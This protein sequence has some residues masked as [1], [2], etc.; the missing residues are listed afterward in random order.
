MSDPMP[1][2]LVLIPGICGSKLRK[3]GKEL[4]ALSGHA[5]LHL[6]LTRG[7][8]LNDLI[9]KA[10]PPD[11]D[12]LGDGVVADGLL[13]DV[14]LI[15]YLWK[16]DGYTKI[17]QVIKQNFKIEPGRNYFEFAYDWR[18]NNSVA[19]RRL[20][21]ESHRWLADWQ[22]SSGNREAKLILIAHSMGGLVSRH[23]LELL[24]GWR[25]TRALITFGTPYRGSLNA[26]DALANGVRK[27]PAGMIDLSAMVRSLTSVYQLLPIYECYDP[28]DGSLVRVGE[29]TGIPNVDATKAA[30]ALAFHRKIGQAVSDH[31]KLDEY[32][33]NGYRI[34]PIVGTQQPTLQSARRLG[35][36][37]ELI[38][39]YRGKD[40]KGDGTVPRVSATPIERSGEGG[41]MF[42]ATRHASL[43]NADAVLAHLHGVITDL[44]LDLG[45]RRAR[46]EPGA[47]LGLDLEDLYWDDE[48]VTIRVRAEGQTGT[49]RAAITQLE[50]NTQVSRA[51]LRVVEGEWQT[52][53]LPRLAPGTYRLTVR[54]E[55]DVD[56]VA[57]VFTV[58]ERTS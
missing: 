39:T 43:Q 12:D 45:A 13:Q 5:A 1:D 47:A 58:F 30:S 3:D 22:A 18:R 32:R 53:E 41:E 38:P 15:P 16:I 10:D 33:Q 23:F 24:E 26:L 36:G 9:L 19:A 40:E 17:S 37:V 56:P 52:A 46:P 57:D 48:P 21:R 11:V 49:A 8:V 51:A 44:Y 4:W 7:Q 20:A 2:V 42:A 25:Q 55:G 29:T 6:L 31:E 27:G 35:A 28:G 34:A 14:H 54:G 50:T